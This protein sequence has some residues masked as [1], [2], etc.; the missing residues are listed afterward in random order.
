[1]D[2]SDQ[3]PLILLSLSPSSLTVLRQHSLE[4][5]HAALV[6]VSPGVLV[7]RALDT[8]RIANF[9]EGRRLRVIA[10]GK[11]SVGMLRAFR[12]CVSEGIVEGVVTARWCPELAGAASF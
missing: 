6:A 4:I 5:V 9:L 7:R 10:A 11:A 12:S 3:D 1:M 8:A 2:G